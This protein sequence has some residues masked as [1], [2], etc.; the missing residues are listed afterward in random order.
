MAARRA[1]ASTGAVTL[2]KRG[3]FTPQLFL[4]QLP[5]LFGFFVAENSFRERTISLAY[6]ATLLGN[7]VSIEGTLHCAPSI[8][9]APSG[10][11]GVVNIEILIRSSLGGFIIVINLA[12]IESI[13]IVVVAGL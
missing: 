2:K 6:L 4:P 10:V 9:V 12:V 8:A 13:L 3:A 5:T 11:V 7:A 1:S